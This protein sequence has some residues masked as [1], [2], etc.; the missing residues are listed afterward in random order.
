MALDRG[1]DQS[2]RR[3]LRGVWETRCA[4]FLG[5]S[6]LQTSSLGFGK[7]KSKITICS[8]RRKI[9]CLREWRSAAP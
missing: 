6:D 7:I 8:I 5:A 1:E 9:C 4:Q 3:V 2:M